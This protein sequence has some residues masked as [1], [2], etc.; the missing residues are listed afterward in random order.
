MS[1][2]YRTKQR[3]NES[4]DRIQQQL[5]GIQEQVNRIEQVVNLQVQNQVNDNEEIK[6]NLI[7]L[8]Q[9][10]SSLQQKT[11]RQYQLVEDSTQV[12]HEVNQNT[13]PEEVIFFMEESKVAVSWINRMRDKV[14]GRIPQRLRSLLSYVTI[15]TVVFMTCSLC[16]M[17][18]SN[19][20]NDFLE[21]FLSKDV[22]ICITEGFSNTNYQ[23]E[24]TD[25]EINSTL[26]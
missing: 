21:P 2:R 6:Q 23:Q 24:N 22:E 15:V 26:Q 8:K 3:K 11:D 5:N 17:D 9:V 14:F 19:N 4:N 12:L 1:N 7:T 16:V 13:Q 10:M 25:V 18:Y 20:A